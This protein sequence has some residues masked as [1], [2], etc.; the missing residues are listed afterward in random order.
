MKDSEVFELALRR[1]LGRDVL[2]DI[3]ARDLDSVSRS[4]LTTATGTS[5]PSR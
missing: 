2:D 3:W 4:V 5:S 1:V